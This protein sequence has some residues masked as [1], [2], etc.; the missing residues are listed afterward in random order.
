[1]YY[2]PA[3]GSGLPYNPFKAC[4]VPRPI[5]WI[6]TVSS[7]GVH[8]LAPYSQFQNLTWDPPTILIAA[9]TRADGS[10]K[11]TAANAID[12]R[13]FVWSM[14]T[15]AQRQAVVASSTE[16]PPGVD[17][18]ERH[19]IDWL[20]SR[21]VKPRRVAGAPVHFECRLQQWLHVP[22]NTPGSGTHLL[23]GEVVGI[24]IDEGALRDGRLDLAAIQPL[25][26]LGYRDYT[27][28][29]EVIE[30]ADLEQTTGRTADTIAFLKEP[31]R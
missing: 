24:H 27:R 9:N 8:N 1:M 17:E 26:R 29:T 10:P 4:C 7:E 12:T 2:R 11:D 18:F 25:A 23:I 31:A 20:P 22:G 13:E 21:E 3:E 6:S 15:W 5:G 19:G 28:V 30:L 14:A 16:H